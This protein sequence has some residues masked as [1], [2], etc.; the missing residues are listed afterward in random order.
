MNCYSFITKFLHRQKIESGEDFFDNEMS[1]SE[2]E[3]VNSLKKL[4][5]QKNREVKSKEEIITLL[6]RDLE[7]KEVLINYLQNEIDKFRQVV[8]PL[9]RKIISKQISLVDDNGSGE[10]VKVQ[11]SV[12][13]RTKRQAISAEPLGKEQKDLHITKFPKSS[14]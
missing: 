1:P 8:K 10:D 14:R 11:P 2:S 4:L 7:K 6:E 3:T 9:T 12:E 5:E 13:Q